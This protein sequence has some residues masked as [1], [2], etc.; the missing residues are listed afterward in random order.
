LLEKSKAIVL[1]LAPPPLRMATLAP[2]MERNEGAAPASAY[3]PD[4]ADLYLRNRVL[5]I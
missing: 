4:T 1:H 2:P 5:L 3:L